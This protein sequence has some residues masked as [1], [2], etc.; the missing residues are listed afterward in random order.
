M[1]FAL[2]QT[3]LKLLEV[4]LPARAGASLII[5][6]ARQVRLFLGEYENECM[7]IEG[8]R[9]YRRSRHCDITETTER[10]NY[11]HVL[12]Q[13]SRIIKDVLREFGLSVD[14]QGGGESGLIASHEGRS[15]FFEDSLYR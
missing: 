2:S 10:V 13:R 4:L 7:D 12:S 8:E 1:E 11:L 6:N 15:L 9:P 5:T 14:H 3:S